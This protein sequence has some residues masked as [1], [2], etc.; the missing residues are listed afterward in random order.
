MNL[1]YYIIT[2]VNYYYTTYVYN[3]YNPSIK[4][5][6]IP[7]HR[8]STKIKGIILLNLYNIKLST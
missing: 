8:I 3:V 1:F 4:Y 2:S 7:S 5:L 6:C